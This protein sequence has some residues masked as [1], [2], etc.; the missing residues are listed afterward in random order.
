[1][2][3]SGGSDDQ[4]TFEGAAR[5]IGNTDA[6]KDPKK[7]HDTIEEMVYLYLK[8]NIATAFKEFFNNN[9]A[10]GAHYDLD[11]PAA[12]DAFT[13][14]QKKTLLMYVCLF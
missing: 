4:A 6:L 2:P 9:T 14:S 10:L 12:F 13:S 5:L 1:M 3:K 7:H 11:D 8:A